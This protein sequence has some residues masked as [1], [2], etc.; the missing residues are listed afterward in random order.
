MKKVFRV[1]AAVLAVAAVFTAGFFCAGAA[2]PGTALPAGIYP[3]TAVVWAL[4]EETDTVWVCTATGFMYGFHGIEDYF[5]GDL[6]SLIMYDNGTE[7]V[8]DDEI[9]S[10]CYSGFFKDEV[11][12]VAV[13]YRPF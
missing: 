4:E 1:I 12:Y 10:A 13:E 6:V 5:E 2:E 8:M 3:E 11:N 7:Y 9:L